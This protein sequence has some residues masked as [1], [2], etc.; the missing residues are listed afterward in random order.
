MMAA[1]LIC[2][3]SVFTACTN[4][5][6]PA[7]PEPR[8]VLV[9]LEFRNKYPAG[10]TMEVYT[11]DANY[12]LVN[13]KEIEISTGEAIADLDYIY[14]PGHITKKGWDLFY[15]ITD[16]CTL[17][18][19]GRIV[20]YHH[21]NVKIET[22]DLLADDYYTITYDENGHIA[23]M[24]LGEMVETYI[25]EGD[26][27][28][29]TTMV[30]K[31]AYARSDFEPSDAPAQAILNRYG[32]HLSELC[33]QGCFGVLPAHMPA[34]KTTLTYLNGTLLGTIVNEFKTTTTADG[35]LATISE[36][37]DTYILHWGTIN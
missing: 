32:Y 36:G 13:M 5:D 9:G 21:K 19:K 37:K 4:D 22:G 25:W 28:R 33:L 34:K 1:I 24:H 8:T 26:E 18:D 23:T 7:K 20:E 15:D 10:P 12:R 35:H 14:T 29:T 3:A 16:E 30:E 17:D 27:L 2:G 11:Y 31:I 6:N